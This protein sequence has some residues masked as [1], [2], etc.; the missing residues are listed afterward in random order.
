MHKT[1][2]VPKTVELEMRGVWGFYFVK[3]A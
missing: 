1:L 3:L 2:L